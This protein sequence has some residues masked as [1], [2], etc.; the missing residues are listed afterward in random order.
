MS[1]FSVNLFLQRKVNFSK[2][3]VFVRFLFCDFCPKTG[4]S[5][6]SA[7]SDCYSLFVSEET[8]WFSVQVGCKLFFLYIFLF[9]SIS[10]ASTL[11]QVLHNSAF[12]VLDFCKIHRVADLHKLTCIC[13]SPSCW[14]CGLCVRYYL[15]NICWVPVCIPYGLLLHFW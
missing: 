1:L 7:V 15:T 8:V 5:S 4:N 12:C 13:T 3:D 14:Q 2:N 9:L 11:L 6:L 10:I